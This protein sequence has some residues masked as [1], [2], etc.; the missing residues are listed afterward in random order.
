MTEAMSSRRDGDRFETQ[1]EGIAV[2]RHLAGIQMSHAYR[3]LQTIEGRLWVL[4][5]RLGLSQED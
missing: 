5:K 2:I 4:V 3:I 1:M